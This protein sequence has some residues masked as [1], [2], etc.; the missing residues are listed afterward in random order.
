MCVR[1]CIPTSLVSAPSEAKRPQSG[2]KYLALLHDFEAF[3]KPVTGDCGNGWADFPLSCERK[4][5]RD[6]LRPLL[7]PSQSQTSVL[8]GLSYSSL[9]QFG[10]LVSAVITKP[11]PRNA[12]GPV[13]DPPRVLEHLLTGPDIKQLF[14]LYGM[15][16][17]VSARRPAGFCG[18]GL[19]SG[20]EAAWAEGPAGLASC[21]WLGADA[22]GRCPLHPC[23]AA[24]RGSGGLSRMSPTGPPFSDEETQAEGGVGLPQGQGPRDRVPDPPS[25][26]GSVRLW[27]RP[28][29]P[30]SG[31]LSRPVGGGGRAQ[32]V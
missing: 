4:P 19:R 13:G 29:T 12:W 24:A 32:C 8:E 26:C 2:V 7:V 27:A 6:P 15:W 23:C 5:T 11:W 16:A 25:R 17:G 30:R 18:D 22:V 31:C 1:T 9:H 28:V 20:R 21:M 3:V 10:K 14:R